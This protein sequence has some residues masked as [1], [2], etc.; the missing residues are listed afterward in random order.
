MSPFFWVFSWAMK[1]NVIRESMRSRQCQKI[2]T[3]RERLQMRLQ[4]NRKLSAD[5]FIQNYRDEVWF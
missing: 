3:R 4:L 1:V 2:R 5:K